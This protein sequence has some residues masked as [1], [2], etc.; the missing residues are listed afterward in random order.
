[1]LRATIAGILA[2]SSLQDKA[3]LPPEPDANAQ[4]DTLKQ[5]K[6]LFKEDYAKKGPADQAALAQKLIQKGIETNDDPTAKFVFLKEARDVAAAA[7]DADT[8]IRAAHEMGKAFAVDGPALKLAVITKMAATTRDPEAA[9]TLA[10]SC[11]ALVADAVR[12]DGYDAAASLAAK[13]EGLARVAQDLNLAARIGDL[14]KEVAS[15]KD[16]YTRVKP[17][18]EKPGTGDEE[19]VGRYLCFVKGD[20]DSGIPHLV[21][22]AKGPLKAL[23][24]KDVLNPMDADKQFDVA[25]GWSDLAQKEKSAWRKSRIQVRVRHWLEK[26]QPNATGVLK[27]KIEKKLGEMEEPEPGT[28]NLLKL[29]DLKL[30]VV[31]G[32]W[33]LDGGV[34][35][36]SPSEFARMQIPYTPPDE[37]D[38]TVTVERRQG[39]DA[40]AVGLV[41]GNANFAFWIDGHPADGWKTGFSMLDGKWVNQNPASLTG[42]L[43]TNNKP[44]TLLLAVRRGG[45]TVS[46]D[47]KV[48]L[49]WQGNYSRMS[50]CQQFKPRDSKAL[51]VGA[52]GCRTAFSKI[53]LTVVSGQGKKTR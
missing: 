17:M 40:T 39:G 29:V 9:R 6:D 4:K 41:H 53:M 24:E 13:A 3:A 16:E 25:E 47:G 15:L 23:V 14:K 31:S 46:L 35:Q 10:K 33:T 19:A 20:W 48:I 44:F 1:M 52:F 32:D 49:T 43:T 36:C 27:L 7:G 11:I 12:V 42:A 45:I 50:P 22:G 34:L 37:Y 51:L 26:A 8:A 2:L 21:A 28:L 18:L 5:I 30:D 38:L